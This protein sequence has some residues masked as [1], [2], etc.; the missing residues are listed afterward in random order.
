MRRPRLVP[1]M[2]RSV[3]WL[4]GLDGFSLRK[5]AAL[6]QRDCPR[7]REPLFLLCYAEGR[8]ERLDSLV[9]R[10][11]VREDYRRTALSLGEI[12]LEQAAIAGSLPEGLGANY[13]KALNSYSAA[14]HRPESVARSKRLR[15]RRSRQ[16]QLEKGIGVSQICRDLGL[17]PGNVNDYLKNGAVSKVSLENATSIMK[18]LAEA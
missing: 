1:W 16:L 15:L 7:A 18:Y 4:C 17:N 5:A 6:S 8:L 3:C 14:Y 12:D 9:Y 11:D 2:R 10:D 13:A